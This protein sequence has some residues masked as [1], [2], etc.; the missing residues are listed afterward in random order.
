MKKFILS[1]PSVL[2]VLLALSLPISGF[3][4]SNFFTQLVKKATTSPNT[5]CGKTSDPG[6]CSCFTKAI[7]DGCHSQPIHP[8][9]TANNIDN[10]ISSL[11]EMGLSY[12]DIC[13][14]FKAPVS[15]AE[16]ATDLEYWHNHSSCRQQ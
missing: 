3:A 7:I 14:K 12:D 16:C 9:C 5:N 10:E 1:L 13:K 4:S 15:L 8:V 2:L 6:F 11:L